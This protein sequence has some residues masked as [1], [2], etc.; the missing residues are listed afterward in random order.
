MTLNE[1]INAYNSV[2]YT[3]N[4]I[5]GFTFNGVVYEVNTTEEILP[6]ILKLDVASRGYGK[7]LRFCPTKEI[8]KTLVSIATPLC[9]VEVFTYEVENSKYNKGEIFE[10]LVTEKFGQVW[11][12]DNVPFTKAGDVEVNG[13]AY[14]IKFEKAT[15]CNE[16]SLAN[17]V[18]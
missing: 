12:K 8:K 7:A 2:A 18:A 16:K 4:Y 1:M 15:F 3:H 6:E 13:I 9:S 14:Q 11:E 17:L 10:K 5:F